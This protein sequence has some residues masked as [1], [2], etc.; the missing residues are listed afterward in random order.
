MSLQDQSEMDPLARKSL[1]RLLKSADK[2]EAGAAVRRPALTD[3]A[4]SEYRELRG[5]KAKEDFE[6]VMAYAQAEG[7][8]MA[9]RPRRDPQG[10]IERIELIDVVKLAS[11][12][13]KVPHAVRVQ[14]ARQTL[15][16]RL[17]EHPIL[18]DVLSSWERLKKIRGTGPDAAANWDMACDVITYC[19][20]QVALG[21]TETPVRDASAR[22]F[23]DSKRIEALVPCLDVLLV[24]NI[25]D[26][27]RPEAEVL[28]ELGLY[29]EPQPARLAGNI[30]VRRE[31]GTFPLD[32]PYGA[33]PPSTVLG[34]GSMPS[35]VLTI[36]NQTTFHVWAR[37]HCDS[38]ALCIYTA[39]MP[40]PAWRA[41]YLRL[42][43]ELPVST[44]VLHWGDV[45]E[46]GFRIAS[47]LSRCVA[48]SG[49]AL[50]PW[51]MRPSDVPESLRRAAPTRTVERMVKYAHEAGW[52]DLAQELAE[53]KFVAE[54]E[55]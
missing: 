39:G 28:Q 44:P 42:L 1:E 13:G 21:A 31:R 37:Q 30:V 46:G 6:A 24:G 34:L 49:H 9:L 22:L 23:K 43:S 38:D 35:R 41:M 32:R 52:T 17:G 18:N 4:L 29:R 40:S 54:Q 36:E 51:R 53:T 15:A 3:S 11:I 19:Q 10:L 33:L 16:S 45:D 20:S 14:S 55:G 2:H 48:E 8:I 27:A 25:D 5:L 26:D 50:R 12:L 7:A 47:V